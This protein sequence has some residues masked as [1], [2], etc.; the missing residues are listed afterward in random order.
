MG[1]ERCSKCGQE[2]IE[3]RDEGDE[4]ADYQCPQNGRT[5]KVT[6]RKPIDEAL[7]VI[8]YA[9]TY[10]YLEKQHKKEGTK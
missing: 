5:E 3:V 10:I 4:M 2:H 6:G 1:I 8:R 9:I 7:R